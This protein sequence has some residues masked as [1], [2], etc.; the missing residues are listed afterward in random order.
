M[1]IRIRNPGKLTYGSVNRTYCG[2]P[3]YLAPEI[4]STYG[5]PNAAY[6]L[7]VFTIFTQVQ[8]GT[9][10]LGCIERIYPQFLQFSQIRIHIEMA[11]CCVLIWIHQYWNC[12]V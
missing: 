9:S 6:D 11:L 3:G 8:Y 1:R 4:L 2:T 7:K 5:L 12:V 10:V